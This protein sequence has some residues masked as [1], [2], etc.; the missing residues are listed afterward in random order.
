MMDV[1]NE[2]KRR[3]G[4]QRIHLL[5]LY[6]HENVHVRLQAAK[7]TLAVAPSEARAQLRAIVD[8]QWFPQSGDAGL[9]LRHLERGLYKPD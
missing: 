1:S 2:L 7:L 4:D 6:T 8:L 9:S 5:D 3:E